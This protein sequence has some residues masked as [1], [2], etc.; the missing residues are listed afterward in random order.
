MDIVEAKTT[1]N[2]AKRQKKKERA[3]TKPLDKVGSGEGQLGTPDISLKRCRLVNGK[4]LV[5]RRPGE[6]TDEDDGDEDGPEPSV[7]EEPAHADSNKPAPVK[8]PH[9]VMEQKITIHE[10][11]WPP[12]YMAPA[13]DQLGSSLGNGLNSLILSR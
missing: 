12:H 5:F 1:K 2:H 13:L 8:Q 7:H 9:I 10:D 3:K 6:D 4:E 11:D